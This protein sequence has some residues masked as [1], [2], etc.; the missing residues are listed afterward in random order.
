MSTKMN[1]SKGNG[2]MFEQ[3]GLAFIAASGQP[4]FADTG[5]IVTSDED[6]ARWVEN[7]YVLF[8]H[9]FGNKSHKYGWSVQGKIH[10]GDLLIEPDFFSMKTGSIYEFK[11]QE[12]EGSIVEKLYKNLMSYQALDEPSYIVYNGNGFTKRFFDGVDAHRRFLLKPEITQFITFSQFVEEQMG[13]PI[14]LAGQKISMAVDKKATM[15]MRK[16]HPKLKEY[17]ERVIFNT[18]TNKEITRFK[19][20]QLLDDAKSDGVKSNDFFKSRFMSC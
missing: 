17:T 1:A 13:M 15:T 11:S 12:T 19:T 8:T 4:Y 2:T 14:H 3:M 6:I 9:Y 16:K 5:Y 7:D 20:L 18:E 10:I